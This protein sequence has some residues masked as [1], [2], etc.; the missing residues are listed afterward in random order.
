MDKSH[1]PKIWEEFYNIF[2]DRLAT[3]DGANFIA[4]LADHKGYAHLLCLTCVLVDHVCIVLHGG[5]D[6]LHALLPLLACLLIL[7]ALRVSLRGAGAA[8]RRVTAGRWVTWGEAAGRCQSEGR[9]WEG[10]WSRGMMGR[11]S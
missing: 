10:R 8:G 6:D 4:E 1:R 9:G 5:H 2:L 11:G 3:N 7:T